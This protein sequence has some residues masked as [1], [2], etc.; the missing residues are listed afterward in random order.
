MHVV[1]DSDC[2]DTSILNTGKRSTLS[3]KVPIRF[4][5]LPYVCSRLTGCKQVMHDPDPSVRLRSGCHLRDLGE[6]PVRKNERHDWWLFILFD[7]FGISK[8]VQCGEVKH[9]LLRVCFFDKMWMGSQ[10]P[11]QKTG[12]DISKSENGHKRHGNE[13]HKYFGAAP[14]YIANCWYLLYSTRTVE[15][16]CVCLCVVFFQARLSEGHVSSAKVKKYVTAL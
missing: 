9:A 13:K 8:T 3:T 14:I 10:Y 12:I 1:F 4:W 16:G 5:M 11:T 2:S 7:T 6:C 15:R